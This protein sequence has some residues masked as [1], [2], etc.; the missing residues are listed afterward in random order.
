MPYLFLPNNNAITKNQIIQFQENLG[1]LISEIVSRACN[2][3]LAF[4][5]KN[6]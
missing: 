1:N 5:L 3:F 4:H 2:L 6:E